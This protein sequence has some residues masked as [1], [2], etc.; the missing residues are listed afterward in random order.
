MNLVEVGKLNK[1]FGIKGFIKVIPL[2]S[3]ASELAKCEVWF[4]N[5]GKDK[6]PYFVESIEYEPHFM[7]K[8]EDIDSPEA[9]KL[10]TGSRILLREKDIEINVE[11][12]DDEL[13]KMI[14]FS[15][16]EDNKLLGVIHKIEE[17]PQQLMAFIKNK[18]NHFMMP[19]TPEFILG[20]DLEQREIEVDLPDGFIESQ[21]P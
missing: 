20:I 1:S 14:D 5:N 13:S 4:I 15:V 18:D 3:F 2:K 12:G 8:F 17:Y 11:D 16:L 7:V 10:I 6:V 21:L 9:A 19:L